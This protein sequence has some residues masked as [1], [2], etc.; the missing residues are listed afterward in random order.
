MQHIFWGIENILSPLAEFRKTS[1]PGETTDT[2]ART[3][4]PYNKYK[5]ILGRFDGGYLFHD[6][7]ALV[8]EKMKN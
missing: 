5:I 3:Q 2:Y 4:K 7:E 6:V 8:L 1:T